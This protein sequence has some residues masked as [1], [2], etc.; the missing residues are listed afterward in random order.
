[1]TGAA[2]YPNLTPERVL[3]E[4]ILRLHKHLAYEWLPETDGTPST[5]EVYER[6]INWAK[7]TVEDGP[8]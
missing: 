4:D 1:M 5:R 8:R 6:L 3:A 7:R 2:V